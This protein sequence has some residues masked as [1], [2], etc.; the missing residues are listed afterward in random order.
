MNEVYELFLDLDADETQI[1]FPIVY[2]NARAG[3]A[4]LSA[5]D[6][7][8]DLKP[9]F[10]VLL[11]TV[12]PPSYD[13]DHPLQALV[14]NLDASP[15]VGR[16]ALCRVRHGTL[17]KG[18]QV[19]WCRADGTIEPA[20][21]HRALRHRGARPRADRRG[22]P[23]RD[24]RHRRAARGHDRRDARR[25]RRPEAAA[26]ERRRRAVP[27][28]HARDQ[29]LPARGAR[30]RQGDREHDQG[31]ARAGAGRQR[32]AADPAD[33][34]AR[35]LGGPGPRRAAA[36]SARRDHAPRGLRAH[37]RQARGADE[38]GRGQAARA[39]RARRD[40]RARGLHRRRDAAARA[41][42]GAHAADGQPRHRLGA[43]GVPRAGPGP[44][45]LPD[46]VPHRDARSRDHAPRVRALRAL[47][48]RAAH[49]SARA[50]WSPTGAGRRPRSRSRTCRSAGRCSSHPA[51]TCTRGWSWARTRA[52]RTWT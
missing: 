18:Q 30:G 31:P 52:A 12:P 45:R 20:Q 41:A 46:G 3:R 21:D 15:Y 28:D 1:E 34:A 29:H 26:G 24:R 42:Q 35:G 13:P 37:R 32:L 47:A 43:D 39:G 23:G 51:S 44:D 16:L 19:A 27:L 49:A 9:L 5:D 10:D 33:G 22:R 6:L 4:G 8:D 36:R 40:R 17:R 7:A 48:R 2:A 25:P 38:A 14:T 50:A 11:E